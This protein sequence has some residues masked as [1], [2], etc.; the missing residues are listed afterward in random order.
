MINSFNKNK[1]MEESSEVQPVLPTTRISFSDVVV[2][3]SPD[4]RNS[5]DETNSYQDYQKKKRTI[6][7]NQCKRICCGISIFLIIILLFIFLLAV[8]SRNVKG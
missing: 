4:N 1:K 8:A 5:L 3:E 6:Q 2:S 7:L